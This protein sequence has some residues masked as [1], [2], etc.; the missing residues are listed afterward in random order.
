[1]IS[2]ELNSN[3]TIQ[4]VLLS[5]DILTEWNACLLNIENGIKCVLLFDIF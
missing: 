3:L 5:V 4:L 2:D 1:M